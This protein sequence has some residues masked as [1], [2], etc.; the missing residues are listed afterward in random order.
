MKIDVERLSE[1]AVKLSVHL[2]YVDFEP[3]IK[4]A[5][6]SI[7]EKISIKGFRKG[8]VPEQV[9]DNQ[10]G[11]A[12]VVQEALND[13]ISN[14]YEK[15]LRENNLKPIGQPE[16]DVTELED[17][18]HI[19][20]TAEVEVRPEFDLPEFSDVRVEVDAVVTDQ[21]AVN[22]QLEALQKRFSNYQV[23]E[24]A[25]EDGDVLLVDIASTFEGETVED[26]T[27]NA[28]SYELGT[29]GILPGFDQAVAGAKADEVRS[30]PFTPEA[31]EYEG[32]EVLVSITVKNVRERALPTLDDDFAQLASEFDTLEE[33]RSDLA[34][35]VMRMKRIEQGYQ[36]RDRVQDALLSMIDVPLPEKFLMSDIDEHFKDGHGD[37]AHRQEYIDGQRRSLKAQ[38]IL[39]K[40]AETEKLSVSEAELSAWLMQQAPRYGMTPQEFADAL[41]QSGGVQMALADVRRIKALELVLQSANVVDSN[42]E[43][44]DLSELDA[45]MAQ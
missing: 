33:L 4:E 6:R 35:K 25:C 10:V 7:A 29:D 15:A 5:Y 41:V 34:D 36:A 1:T 40:I 14:A 45:L 31:G 18:S 13:A 27:A 21:D 23:V 2:D 30:F 11:R 38:F 43:A 26:L 8:K 3:A 37:D 42:G 17:R 12:Y 39:D 9:I 19:A 20:F 24:R 16:V 32:K 22:E 28:L 44:V